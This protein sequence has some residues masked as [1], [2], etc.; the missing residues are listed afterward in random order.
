MSAATRFWSHRS[1][2]AEPAKLRQPT[3]A[4]VQPQSSS[5]S[6]SM[7]ASK[8]ARFGGDKEEKK[9]QRSRVLTMK[10]GKQQMM[11]IRKRIRVETWLE[12]QIEELFDGN[13][14]LIAKCDMDVD[15]VLD[16]ETERERRQ[17]ILD[18][19]NKVGCPIS[20]AQI[21]AFADDFIDQLNTL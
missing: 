19:I 7:N 18:E 9:E 14:Q 12:E 21:Q 17:F 13:D 4:P 20:P 11:L 15:K 6:S 1:P 10:Y 2:A 8:Q 3:T 5:S 16:V